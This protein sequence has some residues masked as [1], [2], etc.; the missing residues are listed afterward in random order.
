MRNRKYPEETCKA[1][2]WLKE[3]INKTFLKIMYGSLKIRSSY[4]NGYMTGRLKL[5]VLFKVT[6]T[7]TAL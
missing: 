7:E 2:Q 5:G 6:T 1:T 3:F 4:I